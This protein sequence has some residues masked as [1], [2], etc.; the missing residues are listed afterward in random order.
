MLR[1][2]QHSTGHLRSASRSLLLGPL[3]ALFFA[4]WS[5]L[6][7]LFTS[8]CLSCRSWLV[9]CASGNGFRSPGTCFSSLRGEFWSAQGYVFTGLFV[10]TH[11]QCEHGRRGVLYWKNQ[12]ETCVDHFAREA[13]NKEKSIPQPSETYTRAMQPANLKNFFLENL[14]PRFLKGFRRLLAALGHLGGSLGRLLGVLGRLLG[15]LWCPLGCLLAGLGRLLGASWLSGT[16]RTWILG[17][18]RR[19]FVALW[20]QVWASVDRHRAFI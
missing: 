19:S 17:V 7:T 3:L 4:L 8:C 9:C 11:M 5:F 10:H 15:C 2:G 6:T 12:Y 1:G 13:K 14:Q 20:R 18:F 16:S